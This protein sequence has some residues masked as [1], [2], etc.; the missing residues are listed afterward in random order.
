LKRDGV[1]EQIVQ[2]PSDHYR[3]MADAFAESVNQKNSV[4]TPLSDALANMKIIDAIFASAKTS[5]WIDI[6]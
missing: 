5:C 2:M 1:R 6:K 4:P 3:N